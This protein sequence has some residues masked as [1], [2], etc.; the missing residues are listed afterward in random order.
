MFL[1]ERFFFIRRV[2][3]EGD[4]CGQVFRIFN[5]FHLEWKETF[6]SIYPYY[7]TKNWTR[8]FLS[9]DWITCFSLS[10]CALSLTPVLFSVYMTLWTE[11]SFHLFST[12]IVLKEKPSHKLPLDAEQMVLRA[13]GNTDFIKLM[14]NRHVRLIARLRKA[15]T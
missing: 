13:L 12:V 8:V 2:A 4:K 11:L 7:K 1:K 3:G 15:R 6:C 5:E 9:L 10:F 14:L